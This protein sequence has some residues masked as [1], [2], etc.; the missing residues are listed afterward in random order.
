MN[1]DDKI[2]EIAIKR[3]KL[4]VIYIKLAK[5]VNTDTSDQEAIDFSNE[6]SP[7]FRQFY[8]EK[9]KKDKVSAL[10]DIK[11]KMIENAIVEHVISIA[12]VTVIKKTFAEAM[13][14]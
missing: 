8:S 5:E 3:V 9:I 11:N 1:F 6:Q 12:T 4:N 14:E 13:D 10:M 7:S 2:K